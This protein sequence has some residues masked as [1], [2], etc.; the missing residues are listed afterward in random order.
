MDLTCL[1]LRLPYGVSTL[2]ISG[3]SVINICWILESWH[4]SFNGLCHGMWSP[5]CNTLPKHKLSVLSS[6][7]WIYTQK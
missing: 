6:M 2:G 5:T 3:S 4:A 1:K 7:D